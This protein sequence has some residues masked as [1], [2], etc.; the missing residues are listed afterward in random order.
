M[1]S[2]GGVPDSSSDGRI[3]HSWHQLA[4]SIYFNGISLCQ[5]IHEQRNE[6]PRNRQAAATLA[7]EG[8][9]EGKRTLH[10]ARRTVTD[11]EERLF[12]HARRSA[13]DRGRAGQ[14]ISRVGAPG[15][16]AQLLETARTLCERSEGRKAVTLLTEGVGGWGAGATRGAGAKRPSGTPAARWG[17]QRCELDACLRGVWTERPRRVAGRTR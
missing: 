6:D 11:R 3:A 8:A 4:N 16:A 9:R 13:G 14:G 5:N 10:G 7:G 2:S 1:L 15:I 17:R 12:S